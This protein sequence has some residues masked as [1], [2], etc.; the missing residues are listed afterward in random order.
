[1]KLNRKKVR[2][3][4]KNKT[5]LIETVRVASENL[6][7]TKYEQG[8]K[9]GMLAMVEALATVYHFGPAR[10]HR[11]LEQPRITLSGFNIGIPG[12][13]ATDLEKYLQQRGLWK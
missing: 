13:E 7:S 9:E 10:M 11:V 3:M 12:D 2:D 5:R 8:H 6:A 1:M 4:A